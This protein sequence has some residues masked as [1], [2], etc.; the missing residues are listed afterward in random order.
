MDS[1]V[2]EG[3]MSK[4]QVSSM[5]F[6]DGNP[7]SWGERRRVVDPSSSAESAV[8]KEDEGGKGDGGYPLHLTRKEIL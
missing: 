3:R 7:S 1:I 6:N 5:C 8:V 2:F 4:S